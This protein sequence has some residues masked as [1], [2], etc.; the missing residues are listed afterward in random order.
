MP[1]RFVPLSSGSKRTEAP[2]ED[3][4]VN[5]AG[6]SI[7]DETVQADVYRNVS[8]DGKL[9]VPAPALPSSSG[10]RSVDPGTL[11]PAAVLNPT[12]TSMGVMTVMGI[13]CK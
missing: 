5:V 6:D 4:I 11:K 10:R 1:F 3:V 12:D 9:H 7:T 2:D 13:E 8:A